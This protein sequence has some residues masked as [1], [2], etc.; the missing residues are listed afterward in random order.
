MKN[1]TDK[2][3]DKTVDVES[4]SKIIIHIYDKTNN[5]QQIAIFRLGKKLT[6]V[7]LPQLC[8]AVF[9]KDFP[10][11]LKKLELRYPKAISEPHIIRIKNQAKRNTKVT[12][13]YEI[14]GL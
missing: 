12:T 8:R 10:E 11:F 2:I 4:S 6:S 1:L 3:V 14:I 9:Q 7:P 5:Q 13:T